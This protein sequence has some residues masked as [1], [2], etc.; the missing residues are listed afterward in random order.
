MGEHRAD[1]RLG[2][3]VAERLPERRTGGGR[4]ASPQIAMKPPI[5]AMTMSSAES[6][7]PGGR[8]PNG[9]TLV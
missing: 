6:A 7:R 5:A 1:R 8:S 3:G 9:V 2:A 4:S